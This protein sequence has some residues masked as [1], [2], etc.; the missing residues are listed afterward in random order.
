[1]IS[2]HKGNRLLL[3]SSASQGENAKAESSHRGRLRNDFDSL[4]LGHEE[5][6]ALVDG[7]IPLHGK[8]EVTRAGGGTGIRQVVGNAVVQLGQGVGPAVDLPVIE[9][10]N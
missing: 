7:S 9:R 4:V 1:M 8:G 2:S 10:R 6:A 3:A 5:R